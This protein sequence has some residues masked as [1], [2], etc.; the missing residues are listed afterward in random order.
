MPSTGVRRLWTARR[1]KRETESAASAGGDPEHR[2]D[3]RHERSGFRADQPA[4]G[5]I[6]HSVMGGSAHSGQRR[7]DGT[8]F[9]FG[10]EHPLGCDRQAPRRRELLR[11]CLQPR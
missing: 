7:T 8:A 6:A 1:E 5:E 10:R 3:E 2:L 4:S 11:A 9:Q